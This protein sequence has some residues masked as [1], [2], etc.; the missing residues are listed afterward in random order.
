MWH[1]PEFAGL[2]LSPFD[3]ASIIVSTSCL[4]EVNRLCETFR[5]DLPQYDLPL[6]SKTGRIAKKRKLTASNKVGN[7]PKKARLAK[8]TKVPSKTKGA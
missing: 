1:C 6:M 4:K 8:V 2:H 7:P 5:K 3:P